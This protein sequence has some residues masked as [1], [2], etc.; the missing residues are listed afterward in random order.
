M[1]F[2]GELIHEPQA[3]SNS[4]MVTPRFH[5]SIANMPWGTAR[6]Y[7]L[8]RVLMRV[9]GKFDTGDAKEQ[10]ALLSHEMGLRPLIHSGKWLNRIMKQ[11]KQGLLRPSITLQ[12]PAL[13]ESRAQFH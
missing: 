7:F 9:A 8:K 11:L 3:D 5:P 2:P 4:V 13:T 12:I 10:I 1:A 6:K